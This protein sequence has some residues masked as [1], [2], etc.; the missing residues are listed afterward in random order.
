MRSLSL[1][2]LTSVA[3]VVAPPTVSSSAMAANIHAKPAHQARAGSPKRHPVAQS[4]CR[5][6]QVPFCVDPHGTRWW[7]PDENGNPVIDYW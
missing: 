2:T 7:H 6:G 5:V 3:L 1:L 4:T